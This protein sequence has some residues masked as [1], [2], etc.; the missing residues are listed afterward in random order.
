MRLSR[1]LTAILVALPFGAMAEENHHGGDANGGGQRAAPPVGMLLE[2]M[3]QIISIIEAKDGD[4]D[5]AE[6]LAKWEEQLKDKPEFKKID[7]NGDGHISR[8]EAKA[9]FEHFESMLKEKMPDAFAKIDANGDGKLSREELH[10]ALE[11]YR[12]EHPQ[13]EH[14]HG[15]DAGNG[16]GGDDAPKP[17]GDDPDAGKH[18]PGGN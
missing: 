10:A 7:T 14:R 18:R 3:E 11:R 8:D 12:Q 13:G 6:K 17:R 4:K 9:A 1:T 5:A 16:G 2:R 15:D